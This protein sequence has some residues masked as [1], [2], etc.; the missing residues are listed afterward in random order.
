MATKRDYYDV[1]GV[2]KDASQQEIKKAYRKLALKYHPDKNKSKD[3]EKKFKEVTEAYEVL[4]DS[5]K[6]STYDQFGHSAFDGA[7]GFGGAGPFTRTYRSGPFTYTY[8][9]SG[10]VPFQ[11]GSDFG[12]F[13]D[14]FEIFEQ[15]FGGA[16]PFGRGPQLPRYSL[17]IDFMDAVEGIEKTI[18]HQGKEHKIKIP[19]GVDDGTRIRFKDFIVSIDVQTHPV[20]KRDGL[21]VFVDHNISF[22]L[23]ALGGTTKV[24]SLG[25]DIKIKIRPGTQPNTLMRLKGKGMNHLRG[26]GRGD[27]YIRLQVK[28]PKNLNRRQKRLI[29]QLGKD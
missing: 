29:R 4:S 1:L 10:G 27:Q 18:V 11:Q 26:R 5:K 20:F 3:A 28:V 7:A 6:R 17:S 14:P 25:G 19:A 24:P 23:A 16:S 8:S 21:D 12:G 22:S 15:F 13:S 2:S 9:T